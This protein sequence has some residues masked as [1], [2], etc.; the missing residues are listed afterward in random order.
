MLSGVIFIVSVLIIPE[1]APDYTRMPM[2]LERAAIE[3]F[4]FFG[5]E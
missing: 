4:D 5:L 3:V 2:C 1:Q